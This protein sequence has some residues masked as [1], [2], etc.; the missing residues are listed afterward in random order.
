[1]VPVVPLS[2]CCWLAVFV[3]EGQLDL[4]RLGFVSALGTLFHINFSSS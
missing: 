4:G 1:M 2:S 3:V